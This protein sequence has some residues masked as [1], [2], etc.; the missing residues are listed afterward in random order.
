[1]ERD[2]LYRKIGGGAILQLSCLLFGGL[3][4]KEKSV[5]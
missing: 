1:M 2:L 5:I 4:L 3:I